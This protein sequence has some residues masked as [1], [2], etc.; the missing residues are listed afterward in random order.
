[1]V[2]NHDGSVNGP[3]N[4]E[5][6]GTIVSIFMTGG[7][8]T[9]PPGVTGSVTGSAGCNTLQQIPVP[10]EPLTA[11]IG[12]QPPEVTFYGEAPG[13]VSGVLQVNLIIPANT[14]RGANALEM[15][16]GG[17]RSQPGV[18]ISVR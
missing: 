18:T 13:L 8:Q 10:L 1:M 2:L 4:P 12:S 17:T 15:S 5:A 16:I 3:A 6:A 11:R 9:S 14:P 7:G